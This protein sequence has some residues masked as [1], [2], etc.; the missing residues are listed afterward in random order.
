M[1]NSTPRERI[2][3][4][5]VLTTSASSLIPLPRKLILENEAQKKNRYLGNHHYANK[6]S[7]QPPI[8]LKEHRCPP[9]PIYRSSMKSLI[10][11]VHEVCRFIL[12]KNVSLSK[13]QRP[14]QDPIHR[15]VEHPRDY[16]RFCGIPIKVKAYGYMLTL[17]YIL[18]GRP[19]AGDLQAA[20]RL[21]PK[22]PWP[23][24]QGIDRFRHVV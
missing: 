3:W 11:V 9:T 15:P 19:Y 5:P 18:P 21:L 13:P 10:L 4:N 2:C 23:L 1:A 17:L 20:L 24:A 16:L 22:T 7:R 14:C 6:N 8:S 12:H